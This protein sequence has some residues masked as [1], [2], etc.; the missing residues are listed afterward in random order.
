MENHLDPF[1]PATT[2][3][4]IWDAFAPDR[5]VD[6]RSRFYIPREDR[7]LQRLVFRLVRSTDKEQIFFC[8][9]RG[10]GKTT[11]LKRIM[12]SPEIRQRYQTVYLTSTNFGA[13]PVDLTHD[14]LLVE[15]GLALA[16]HGREHGMDPCLAE[17]LDEWGQEIV[18][19]FLHDEAAQAAAGVKANAWLAFF[20]AQLKTRRQWETKQVQILEPK[21]QDLLSILLRMAQDLENR[22]GKRLLVLVDD[23]EKGESESH[24]GMH[25]RIF[26]EQYETLIQTGF[27]VIYTIPIYFRS[28]PE[29]RIPADRLYAFPA[30]RLYE[31]AKKHDERPQIDRDL[32]GYRVLRRFVEQRLADPRSVLGED[33]LDELLLIG[34][35]LFR[36]TARAMSEAAFSAYRRGASR[37]EA[38]DVEEVFHE[39]KKDYQPLIRGDAV[40]VLKE[41]LHS[42]QGW[43]PG[44]E[45]YL[46]SHTVVEYENDDLWLDLRYFL[47]QYVS[48]MEA[49]DE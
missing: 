17:E 8:G 39:L 35:G 40:R 25:W 24:K 31:R 4:E 21:V 38:R 33:L 37:I 44:I 30:V 26:Q 41:V 19:T 18:K 16:E 22:G 45:P 49:I 32:P 27:S 5:M 12:A 46:Q 6:P 10:S 15:I 34:G 3:G 28:L 13:D 11:E 1:Q 36:E 7:G 14:A 43:I 2:L 47:K 9:H 20:K 23:L 42:A 29:R 48:D